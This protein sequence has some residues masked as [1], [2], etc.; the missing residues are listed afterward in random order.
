MKI[1]T[2]IIYGIAT[3]F[4]GFLVLNGNNF[5][6]SNSQN[7]PVTAQTNRL[8]FTKSEQINNSTLPTSNKTNTKENSPRRL[9][10]TVKVAE[11]NDLKIKEEEEIKKGQIINLLSQKAIASSSEILTTEERIKMIEERLELMER[12]IKYSRKRSWT[13][14]I[15]LDPI[16]LI[17]NIFGGGGVQRDRI[18]LADLDVS[19]GQLEAAKAEL[20]RQK[21]RQKAVLEAEV[22]RLVLNYEAS[23][24]RRDLIKTQLTTFQKQQQIELISYRLGQ[25]NTNEYLNSQLRSEELQNNLLEAET[26]IQQ[27]L[28]EISQLT[29]NEL[30]Q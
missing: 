22:L 12:K 26:L 13:N 16:E 30:N 25:G 14:Y 6:N 4:T 23:S 3:A 21:E 19:V 8:N 2:F 5:N 18:A 9:A 11:P 10:I 20:E 15:T 7:N 27:T 28:R 29:G 1:S 17:Q 24:R